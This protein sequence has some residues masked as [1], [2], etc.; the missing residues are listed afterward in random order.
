MIPSPADQRGSFYWIIDHNEHGNRDSR[1]K[2]RKT[3]NLL[4]ELRVI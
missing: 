1:P 2:K 4:R 3:R